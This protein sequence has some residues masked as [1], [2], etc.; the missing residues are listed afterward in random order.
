MSTKSARTTAVPCHTTTA[1]HNAVSPQQTGRCAQ[2]GSESTARS[3]AAA[4]HAPAAA[5]PRPVVTRRAS[6]SRCLRR[7]SCSPS[8]HSL[9][10]TAAAA[11][12]AST[13]T[14]PCTRRRSTG[15]RS[16]CSAPRVNTTHQSRGMRSTPIDRMRR[17]HG[18]S[19]ASRCTPTRTSGVGVVVT[20]VMFALNSSTLTSARPPCRSHISSISLARIGSNIDGGSDS[21][22]A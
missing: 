21:N 22:I 9:A 4:L 8:G 2:C 11:A 12:R 16:R 14:G 7:A 5:R 18:I 17:T 6:S 15:T 20:P 1:Q 10:P 19:S 13:A 3:A